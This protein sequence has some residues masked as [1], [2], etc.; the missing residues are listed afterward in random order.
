MCSS[1]QPDVSLPQRSCGCAVRSVHT[2]QSAC[3]DAT[4][5][6]SAQAQ[7]QQLWLWGRA[8]GRWAA[9][10]SVALEWCSCGHRRWKRC[11]QKWELLAAPA[12]NIVEQM[13][14]VGQLNCVERQARPATN[15]QSAPATC[16]PTKASAAL[17]QHIKDATCLS[18]NGRQ[19]ACNNAWRGGRGVC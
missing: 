3:F 5:A 6:I 19:R 10:G 14:R 9:P 17:R 4:A 1:K 15:V 12:S 8:A 18:L 11:R 2:W 16:L 7:E 13:V